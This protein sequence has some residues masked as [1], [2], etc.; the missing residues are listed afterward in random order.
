MRKSF[1]FKHRQGLPLQAAC[2]IACLFIVG[3]FLWG[4]VPAGFLAQFKPQNIVASQLPFSA[5]AKSELGVLQTAWQKISAPDYFVE[6]STGI[7]EHSY[8][9]VSVSRQDQGS[10]IDPA[11]LVDVP[12]EKKDK[13][14]LSDKPLIGIYCTHSAESY[15]PTSGKSSD[16]GNNGD[17]FKV[18]KSLQDGLKEQGIASVLCDT[19]H[20][21][22][23]WSKSY[24][25]S[26]ASM[27]KMQEEHPSLEIF[28]DVHRDSYT[29][30][31]STVTKI[32]QQK[33]AKMMLVV[34]SNKRSK[35]DNWQENLAFSKKVGAKLEEKYPG[36]LRE[37]RVQSGRYN[38]HF[39]SKA[40][41]I[42]VGST[43]NTLEQAQ[44]SARFMAEV[45]CDI[46]KE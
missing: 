38:Q 46:V 31:L 18:A 33:V 22:P 4:K 40:I 9:A 44:K 27:K 42:E 35:H 17:I 41:L 6:A 45:L 28:V 36:V 19:I 10:T 39:S 14:Q 43:E 8:L 15:P 37:V 11:V 30:N 5:L 26:L 29:K 1:A 34:G 21:Y 25:N 23:Q 20:D 24:Q 2:L 32:N 7:G 13:K 16:S 3:C 12:E